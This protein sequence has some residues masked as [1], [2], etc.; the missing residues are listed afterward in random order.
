METHGAYCYPGKLLPKNAT[1]TMFMEVRPLSKRIIEIE[2]EMLNSD[3]GQIESLAWKL[4]ILLVG[5]A[6]IGF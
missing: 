2:T 4:G 5:G 1:I 3:T 6:V